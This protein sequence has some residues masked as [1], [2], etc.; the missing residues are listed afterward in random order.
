MINNYINITVFKNKKPIYD[1]NQN[2][3]VGTKGIA[4]KISFAYD[5]GFNNLIG[6]IMQI[7]YKLP[8]EGLYIDEF[9]IDTNG[10]TVERKIDNRC[11]LQPGEIIFRIAIKDEYDNYY[12]QLPH[13]FSINVKQEFVVSSYLTAPVQEL[14]IDGLIK[15]AINHVEH[16]IN[17]DLDNLI[18]SLINEK[19][20]NININNNNNNEIKTND[21]LENLKN[22]LIE[23]KKNVNNMSS[24]IENCNKK[25]NELKLDFENLLKENNNQ[26]EYKFSD[27]FKNENNIISLKHEMPILYSDNDFILYKYNIKEQDDI[28]QDY[29]YENEKY[30]FSYFNVHIECDIIF[31]DDKYN[32]NDK[33]LQIILNL[34]KEK[35]FK[36]LTEKKNDLVNLCS[37][38]YFFGLNSNVNINQSSLRRWYLSQE[39]KINNYDNLA[40]KLEVED[41]R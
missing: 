5:Y 28:I 21:N 27:E 24:Y 29:I 11:F 41:Y 30:I 13:D 22:E 4:L 3:T 18:T 31:N 38:M 20:N 34:E 19:L 33:L 9:Q 32:I 26:V 39:E 40:L 10:L 7:Q 6:K 1:S 36:I 14:M 35:A 16:F 23:F 15:R 2:F 12:Y 17:H 25:I 8:N 37:T